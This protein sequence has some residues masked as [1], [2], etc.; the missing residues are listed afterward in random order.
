[1]SDAADNRTATRYLLI[2]L[3]RVAA[4]IMLVA[5]HIGEAI[6]NPILDDF[7]IPDFYC[8][9]L[10][11][12]SVSIFLIISGLALE[13]QYGKQ[14]ASFGTFLF[15]RVLR[16]YPIYYMSLI[17]GIAVYLATVKNKGSVLSQLASFSLADLFNSL[18][19]FYAFSGQWGGPFVFTSWFIG[20]IMVMYFFFPVI[21]KSVKKNPTASLLLLFLLSVSS[22]VILGHWDILPGRPLDWFPSCRVFEFGMGVYL[23]Y[24]VSSGFWMPEGKSTFFNR[25]IQ[26]FSE[27]SFPLFLIHYPL[28]VVIYFIA[29]FKVHLS[30]AIMGYLLTSVVIGWMFLMVDKRLPRSYISKA[31]LG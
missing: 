20:L 2:D 27:L 15:R 7:G 21:S 18:T 3:I 30:I 28:L 17:L 16:I 8:V 24:R 12:L 13:L 5:S 19:G 25:A 29:K 14:A 1:M 23:G 6:H 4:I 31:V 11:G 10:G 9:S 26:F 22:R